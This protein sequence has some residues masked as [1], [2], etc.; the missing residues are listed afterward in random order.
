MIGPSF[1]MCA[2]TPNSVSNLSFNLFADSRA[3][4]WTIQTSLHSSKWI[5]AFVC[6][7]ISFNAFLV[8]LTFLIT[9]LLPFLSEM[10]IGFT[11]NKLPK[12]AAVPLTRPAAFKY[13]S[14]STVTHWLFVE[15]LMEHLSYLLVFFSLIY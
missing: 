6:S 12:N 3:A 14:V 11:P 7:K 10:K 5:F 4:P 9:K 15:F 8:P 1:S 13:V 2:V